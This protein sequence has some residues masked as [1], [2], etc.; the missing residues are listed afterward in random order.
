MLPAIRALI[1][2]LAL[3]G[4]TAP[5]LAQSARTIVVGVSVDQSPAQSR[6]LMQLMQR[7]F[8]A[9]MER[10]FELVFPSE[11]V[12]GADGTQEGARRAHDILLGDDEVDLVIALGPLVSL[13][14]VGRAELPKPVIAP[15]AISVLA[16]SLPRGESGGSGIDNLCYIEPVFDFA[17]DV[18]RFRELVDFDVLGILGPPGLLELVESR[19]EPVLPLAE[20]GLRL[21]SSSIEGTPEAVV[22]R[23]DPDV[24]AVFLVAHPSEESRDMKALIDALHA[25]GLPTFS[26][27]GELTVREGALAGLTPADWWPRLMRRTAL[28]ARRILVGEPAS[29][30]PTQLMRQEQLY[31]NMTA[32]RKLGISPT[33]DLMSDAELVGDMQRDPARVLNLPEV[34]REALD[35]NRDV[36]AARRDLEAGR[37]D[38]SIARA[39]LLPQLEAT[40]GGRLIDE[41]RAQQGT[42]GARRTLAA[43]AGFSQTIWSEQAWANVTV[44][45]QLVRS[46]EAS[47]RETEL[48]VT[49]QAA[50]AYFDVLS[51]LAI[52]QIR[53]DNLR[54]TRN[55]LERA[56]VRLRLGAASPAEEYRWQS[57]VAQ[58]QDALVT[59]IAQRNLAE[60]ELNRVLSRPLEQK[61]GV[62]E[63]EGTDGVLRYLDPRFLPYI[64]DPASLRL[65][66]AYASQVGLENSPELAQLDAAI[67]VQR[68]LSESETRSF[69]SPEIALTG[70]L[71]QTL[72]RGGAGA[73]LLEQ[74]PLDDL[75]WELQL[76]LRLPL[77]EGGQRFARR[78]QLAVEILRLQRQREAVA[79]RIEQ[80]VRSTIHVASASFT[81][82]KLTRRARDAARANLELVADAY[83]Q[84][85]VS[86]IELLDAQ[87]AQFTAEQQAASAAF[88]FL[89]DVMEV[90]RA[91]GGF[92]LLYS[93]EE[94]DAVFAKLEA[95]AEDQRSDPLRTEE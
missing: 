20:L 80:R 69:F 31:I 85:A 51:A 59:S 35:R 88:Q 84:G 64:D 57:Q 23:L 37:E 56:R 28:H 3:F 55:N 53:A 33:F 5:S 79:E 65:L 44:Q 58:D 15:M 41:D 22:G 83:A 66:R 32:A 87:T 67:A 70:D 82:I 52:Q 1:L 94:K 26:S 46:L 63:P 27:A 86:I 14:M 34:L 6:W 81:R 39:L 24:E 16:Q 17:H 29:Q 9:L 43:G 72:D 8:R 25:Q 73:E 71:T 95:Y 91:S 38:V 36:A 40:I 78:S 77:F 12:L 47:L 48:D 92:V 90:E 75:D 13:E 21:V 10:E 89:S 62:V 49:L 93:Q 4:T 60:I 2:L 7:E 30:L 45:K 61:L 19:A 42:F 54:L 18:E 68:R 50:A 74:S 11:K 76:G